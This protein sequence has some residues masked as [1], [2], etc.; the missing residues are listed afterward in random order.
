MK[1]FFPRYFFSSEK[2]ITKNHIKQNL[3]NLFLITYLGS[4]SYNNT[5]IEPKIIKIFSKLSVIREIL[6]KDI[7]AA[8]DAD[9]SAKSYTEI[10]RNFPGF[11]S[12]VIHRF[13]HELYLQNIYGY[14][15][16]LSE[17]ARTLTGID[18]H[19]GAKIK[20]YFFIDHGSGT[21]IGETS[22][23]GSHVRLYHG[24]TLGIL[25]FKH[26]KN[27]SVLKKGYK[28]HPT[29]GNNII[30]GTGAKILGPI[31]IA[32][33]VNIGAN[34]WIQNDVSKNI[35]FYIGKHPKLV[36]KKL[37]GEYKIVARK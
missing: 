23:I 12:I 25:H 5:N 19:P 11:K 3:E 34:S 33:N 24:V 18:I 29:L 10:I 26:Q 6:K 15:R 16:E 20:E 14:S 17:L 27:S 31:T 8:Y 1:L 22:E 30:V 37:G 28:R 36:Y 2:L 35:S 32:D 9:P 7:K 13:S 4:A 21:V